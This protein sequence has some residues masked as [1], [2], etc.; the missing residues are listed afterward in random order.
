VGGRE[1]ATHSP[2]LNQGGGPARTPYLRPK[3]GLTKPSPRIEYSG[4]GQH[5]KRRILS[6]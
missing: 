4:E 1:A 6:S 2:E 5:L 3:P